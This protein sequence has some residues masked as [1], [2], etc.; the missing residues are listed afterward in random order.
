[1]IF[2]SI[3]I[4]SDHRGYQMKSELISYFHEI[5]YSYTDFGTD[6]EDISVDYPDFAGM[7]TDYVKTHE[8]AL[9]IL[10]DTV[11][12]PDASNSSFNWRISL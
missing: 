8:K 12:Y 11:K 6:N 7:V 3:A 5:G 1:M 2:N 4:A 9:G 10:P